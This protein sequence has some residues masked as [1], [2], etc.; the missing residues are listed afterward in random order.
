MAKAKRRSPAIWYM[1]YEPGDPYPIAV[2][3]EKRDAISEALRRSRAVETDGTGWTIPG[4]AEH[5]RRSRQ[6]AWAKLKRLG[7]WIG[8]F[9][10]GM[11]RRSA[12]PRLYDPFSE[13]SR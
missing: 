13:R 2:S 11:F 12:S 9:P 10:A 8:E 5:K 6:R 4:D 7:W 3:S 1:V